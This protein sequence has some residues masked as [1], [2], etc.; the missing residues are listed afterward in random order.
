ME[1]T[2]VRH[3]RGKD[4][5]LLA[6]ELRNEGWHVYV[7]PEGLARVPDFF[8]AIKSGLPLDPPL[9]GDRNWDALADSLWEGL[10]ALEDG[11]IAIVWPQVHVG[12]D[13]ELATAVDVLDQ[14]AGLLAD[15]DAT[16][17]R[18]KVVHVILT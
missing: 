7:L 8:R 5:G 1:P 6:Q 16:V 3:H 9:T 17:G 4:A 11:R 13:A 10:N 2:Y 14:V 12:A 15:P 18:P